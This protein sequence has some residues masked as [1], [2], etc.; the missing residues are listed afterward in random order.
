MKLIQLGSPRHKQTVQKREYS[1][2]DQGLL[3]CNPAK[4][5]TSNHT[6]CH[7]G[8][9]LTTLPSCTFVAFVVNGLGNRPA[10][11]IQA[12]AKAVIPARMW[13]IGAWTV[14]ANLTICDEGTDSAVVPEAGSAERVNQ[15]RNIVLAG[16]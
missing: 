14:C 2:A 4:P 9:G 13:A 1:I 12:P 6:Y 7:E 15:L 11:E 8:F 10:R 16:F 5:R 3:T